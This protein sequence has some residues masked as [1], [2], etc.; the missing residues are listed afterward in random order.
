MHAYTG[1][2]QGHAG[3]FWHLLVYPNDL[4]L[5]APLSSVFGIAAWRVS[6]IFRRLST[7]EYFVRHVRSSHSGRR[8][9]PSFLVRR[10]KPPRKATWPKTIS[11]PLPSWFAIPQRH[12]GHA[13]ANRHF[14]HAL[15]HCH[16][17]TPLHG[18]RQRQTLVMHR[19]LLD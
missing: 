4:Q 14:G 15:A 8:S 6:R 13:P 3:M 12:C 10:S 18:S 9:L 2:A 5:S 16:L 7:S 11:L 17:V 1:C 19:F